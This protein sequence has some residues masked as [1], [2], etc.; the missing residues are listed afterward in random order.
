MTTFH[1]VK[2]SD[3]TNLQTVELLQ[4]D[5]TLYDE[6]FIQ[7]FTYMLTVDAFR[8]FLRQVLLTVRHF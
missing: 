2:A 3:T 5:F 4:M 7:G 8:G 1:K 6:T